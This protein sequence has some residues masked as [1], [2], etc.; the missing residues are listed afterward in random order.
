MSQKYNIS[1]QIKL[2]VSD[3]EPSGKTYLTNASDVIAV[4][5]MAFAVTW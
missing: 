5:C 4:V 2:T 1:S 3:D